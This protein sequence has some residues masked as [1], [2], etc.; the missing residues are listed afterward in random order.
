[1][2]EKTSIEARKP[3]GLPDVLRHLTA[4]L[5][6]GRPYVWLAGEASVVRALRRH[7]VGTLGVPKG[8]VCFTGYWRC[9][10]TEEQRAQDA[11]SAMARGEDPTEL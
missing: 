5:P 4:D 6:A 8:D 2:T 11:I 1:M 3:A 10:R 7:V 9:G